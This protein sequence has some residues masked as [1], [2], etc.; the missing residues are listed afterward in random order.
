MYICVQLRFLDFS[1]FYLTNK[2]VR[3]NVYP[4]CKFEIQTMKRSY[5]SNKTFFILKP[6]TLYRPTLV[7]ETTYALAPYITGPVGLPQRFH[8]EEGLFVSMLK[9]LGSES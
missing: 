2:P 3:I 7:V 4:N 8:A 1:R 6:C 5:K 9:D